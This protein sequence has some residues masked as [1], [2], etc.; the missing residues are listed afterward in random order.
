MQIVWYLDD[1]LFWNVWLIIRTECSTTVQID[2]NA[3]KSRL[4]LTLT[5]L[6]NTDMKKIDEREINF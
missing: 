1:A 4:S 5:V 6:G 3:R 2:Q